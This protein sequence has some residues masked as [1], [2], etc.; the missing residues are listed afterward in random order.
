M[1]PG[2]SPLRSKISKLFILFYFLLFLPIFEIKWPKSEEKLNFGGRW[3]WSRPRGRPWQE[4]FSG[5]EAPLDMR[6][7]WTGFSW[8]GGPLWTGDHL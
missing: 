4:D 2:P 1:G 8:S 5:Q 6:L 7:T 3:F